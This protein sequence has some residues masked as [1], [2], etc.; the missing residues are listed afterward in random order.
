MVKISNFKVP[1][2]TIRI[3]QSHTWIISGISPP[4]MK[5]QGVMLMI[6]EREL[7]NLDR[8][9]SGLRKST[10]KFKTFLSLNCSMSSEKLFSASFGSS[11]LESS[12]SLNRFSQPINKII[13]NKK[14]PKMI[15]RL[16]FWPSLYY[17]LIPFINKV[18]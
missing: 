18:R 2:F 15:E 12:I 14:S 1:L 8:N 7:M 5:F 10:R 11:L 3:S 17:R 16:D 4:W 9:I 6:F 13:N